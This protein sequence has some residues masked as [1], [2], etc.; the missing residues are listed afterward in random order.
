[1]QFYSPSTVKLHPPAKLHE[2]VPDIERSQGYALQ[3]SR[4]LFIAGLHMPPHV[5][6]QVVLAVL[7]LCG[8]CLPLLTKQDGSNIGICASTPAVSA[9]CG[10][11][12]VVCQLLKVCWTVDKRQP[13]PAGSGMQWLLV[14]IMHVAEGSMVT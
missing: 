13:G 7:Q 14:T 8:G 3:P 2:E 1:M 4:H 10:R 11:S 6:P 5:D 12:H 9:R